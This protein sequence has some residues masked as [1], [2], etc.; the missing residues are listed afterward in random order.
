MKIGLLSD[1]HGYLDPTVFDYFAGVDEIWHAGDIGSISVAK[2]LQDFKPLRAVFGNVDD[3]AL[4]EQY[5]ENLWFLSESMNVW[6][7]HIAGRPQHYARGITKLLHERAP[8]ILV[9]GHSHIL[10]VMKDSQY[11]LLYLNPGA[12]GH[13]GLHIMRTILRFEISGRDVRNMEVIELGKRGAIP[14]Q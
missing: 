12:A 8:D 14:R 9:C 3:T 7:T 6:I 11:D 5:P 2:S 10:R 4:R 1:T 13:Q